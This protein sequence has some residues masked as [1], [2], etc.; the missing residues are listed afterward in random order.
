MINLKDALAK[1]IESAQESLRNHSEIDGVLGLM[2]DE[3]TEYSGGKVLLYTGDLNGISKRMALNSAPTGVPQDRLQ[4][5]VL[6]TAAKEPNFPLA[7][8]A[9]SEN[10]YPCVLLFADQSIQA[11]DK[12]SLAAA[13]GELLASHATGNIILSLMKH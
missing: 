5:I 8:L 1:G 11:M 2:A 7:K 6:G 9:R 3:I 10:G 13:V 12:A 4:N